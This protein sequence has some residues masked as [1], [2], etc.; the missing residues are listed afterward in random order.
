MQRGNWQA[1]FEGQNTL[2]QGHT[3]QHREWQAE[4]QRQN[5]QFS[6]QG[7]IQYGPGGQAIGAGWIPSQYRS[8]IPRMNYQNPQIQ[9]EASHQ[10]AEDPFGKEEWDKL[11]DEIEQTESSKEQQE[12][13]EP[14][15]LE[16]K[17]DYQTKRIGADLIINPI[18]DL[19]RDQ[20]P[21]RNP[22]EENEA[23]A[24]TAGNLLNSVSNNQDEKFQNS[25]FLKLMEAFR[26]RQVAVQGNK[27]VSIGGDAG[28]GEQ[29]E[30]D[31]EQSIP[32]VGVVSS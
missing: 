32:H 7:Q 18:T 9:P 20:R 1:E 28:L 17:N 29:G 6:N 25:R 10:A 23:L 15:N 19:P 14:E 24:R 13:Y 12:H 5:T 3:V 26:D 11:F 21:S 4:A 2:N 22:D 8:D 16:P 27:I 30:Y 31:Q